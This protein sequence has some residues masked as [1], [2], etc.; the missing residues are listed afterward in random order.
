LVAVHHDGEYYVP[1]WQFS[2]SA[3]LGGL[4]HVIAAWHGSSLE[5]AEWPTRPSADLDGRTPAQ[6]LVDGDVRAVLE[7]EASLVVAS[8]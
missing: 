6:A 5:L 7:L 3:F 2:R 4:D 8:W 1:D